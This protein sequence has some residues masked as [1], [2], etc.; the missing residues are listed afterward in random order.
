[1]RAWR[2]IW[3]VALLGLAGCVP[4]ER[5]ASS[6]TAVPAARTASPSR[7][8][9]RPAASP[10][11]A[12]AATVPAAAAI[13]TAAPT[14]A[15]VGEPGPCDGA[16]AGQRAQPSPNAAFWASNDGEISVAQGGPCARLVRP[17]WA[18]F[19]RWTADS[20]YA[21]Y[22]VGDQYG[23]SAGL[24]FDTTTWRQFALPQFI[25]LGDIAGRFPDG[26]VAVGPQQAR[27]LLGLG[28]IVVLPGTT[29]RRVL[30]GTG[31]N[32]ILRAAWSPDETHL[33]FLAVADRAAHEGTYFIAAGDGEGARALLTVPIGDWNVLNIGWVGPDHATLVVREGTWTFDI[34]TLTAALTPAA[35]L[36]TPAP[37]RP[38]A[39][40]VHPTATAIAPGT[41]YITFFGAEP[42]E[43]KSGDTVI[44]SWASSD[45]VAATLCPVRLDGRVLD[46][47][48]Q[49]VP[50]S[51]Q[52]AIRIGPEHGS[53]T[54]F[55]L[56]VFGRSAPDNN[57]TRLDI[58][59]VPVIVR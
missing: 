16:K 33:A 10:A 26:P 5:L 7:T 21:V 50:V 36:A 31:Q 48:C 15:W 30:D 4:V 37:A 13:S 32:V 24:V 19:I 54:A 8:A 35:P 25:S 46:H 53:V 51:G 56:S 27:I 11:P 52:T 39:T 45:G 43:A 6:A 58:R 14:P 29:G 2:L 1:M 40:P 41:P 57:G 3:A 12:A 34:N 20:R 49:A 55:S 47:L 42:G 23:N 9:T 22:S 18:H 28:D 17:K 59:D 38:S 44:F